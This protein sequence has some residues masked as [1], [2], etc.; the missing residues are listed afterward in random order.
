MGVEVSGC[1][2]VG[3]SQFEGVSLKGSCGVWKCG[4]EGLRCR[5]VSVWGSH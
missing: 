5:R 3:E 1:C 4:V 2:S